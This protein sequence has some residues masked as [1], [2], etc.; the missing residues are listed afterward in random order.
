MPFRLPGRCPPITLYGNPVLRTHAQPVTAFDRDLASLV[1][2]LFDTMYAIET[3][4]G[5]AANQIGR[6]ERV[7]VF[8]CG[9]DE[10]GYVVNPI[11]E[12]IGD[13]AQ[14]GAEGCLSVPGVSVPTTRG[15]RARVQ[16]LDVRGEP[17]TYEGEGLVARCFQHEVDHLDGMLYVDRHPDLLPAID[18]HLQD[19]DWFGTA[20]LDPRSAQYRRAQAADRPFDPVV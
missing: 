12:V 9:E 13:G 6:L 14:T 3:G 15:A 17:V 8:D 16:G 18:R 5:L 10:T 1:D 7:F 4:V 11:V 20:A 19:S 2:D